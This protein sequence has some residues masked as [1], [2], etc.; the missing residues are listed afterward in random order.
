M[1]VRGRL[2]ASLLCCILPIS[3]AYAEPA[4]LTRAEQ[5]KAKAQI[6]EVKQPYVPIVNEAGAKAFD[7]STA[8]LV[9]FGTVMGISLYQRKKQI[10]EEQGHKFTPAQDRELIQTIANTLVGDPALGASLVTMQ[11]AEK[12]AHPL[13]SVIR[14]PSNG[15]I[16][17]TLIRGAVARSMSLAIAMGSVTALETLY[18]KAVEK[19][20]PEDRGK[21]QNLVDVLTSVAQKPD[22]AQRR[23]EL[24]HQMAVTGQIAANMGRIAIIEP[25][26]RNMWLYD[27]W[28]NGIATGAFVANSSMMG[29]GGAGGAAIGSAVPVIGTGVGAFAGATLGAAAATGLLTEAQKGAL[30]QRMMDARKEALVNRVKSCNSRLHDTFL[31]S[32]SPSF[33]RQHNIQEGDLLRP[34]NQCGKLREGWVTIVMDELKNA[35]SQVKI[36]QQRQIPLKAESASEDLDKARAALER[37][38]QRVTKLSSDLAAFYAAQSEQMRQFHDRFKNPQSVELLRQEVSR[39]NKVA[40]NVKS[41]LGRFTEDDASTQLIFASSN[42]GFEESGWLLDDASPPPAS[43]LAEPQDPQ[44]DR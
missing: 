29:L 21:G 31:L 14:G 2:C 19:L 7:A 32:E 18:E 15:R 12:L 1:L 35:Y 37:A 22:A 39:L 40:A 13:T 6:L 33:N 23:A 30:T 43:P 8:N 41:T 27:T 20:P 36:A 16:S 10:E 9:A 44:T 38:Q 34:L 24:S 5:L 42:A 4:F 3:Q 28:R 11:Q 25:G 17:S 26:A